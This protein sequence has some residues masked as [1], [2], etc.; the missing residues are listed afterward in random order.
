MARPSDR[1][2]QMGTQPGCFALGAEIRAIELHNKGTALFSPPLNTSIKLTWHLPH[3][4]PIHTAADLCQNLFN[5]LRSDIMQSIIFAWKSPTGTRTHNVGKKALWK[6]CQYKMQQT[7]ASSSEQFPCIMVHVENSPVPHPFLQCW[8]SHCVLPAR[9]TVSSSH[10]SITSSVAPTGEFLPIR[11]SGLL[12]VC[13]FLKVFALSLSMHHLFA[14]SSSLRCLVYTR[15]LACPLSFQPL[16]AFQAANK[17]QV[18]TTTKGPS[19]AF[20]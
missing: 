17:R 4:E 18:P 10:H 1:A 3:D 11:V 5:V 15:L 19:A 13:L 6:S 14:S 8:P 7:Y 2:P 20:E 12:F 9:G 16:K